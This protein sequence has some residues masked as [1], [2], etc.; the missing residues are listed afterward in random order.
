MKHH[1]IVVIGRG[2]SAY[3]ALLAF[4]KAGLKPAVLAP[5][6]TW[7][8]PVS[9][10]GSGGKSELARKKKFGS[11]D[12]YLYPKVA[13]IE[14]DVD[15]GIPISGTPGGLS[16]VWGSNIEVFSGP[17][18]SEWGESANQMRVA[19]AEVLCQ[20]PHGGSEDAL[21]RRCPW[22][23]DFPGA[24]PLSGRVRKALDT[25]AAAKSQ[26]SGVLVGLARNAIAPLGQGCI[27]CG[28]C[29]NGCPE[30]VIFDAGP[31]IA[32]LI[33]EFDLPVIDALA[34]KIEERETQTFITAVDREHNSK[35]VITASKV[36]LAAGSVATAAM[37]T[38]SEL[39]TGLATLDDTQVFYTPIIPNRAP[40]RGATTFTLAQ[41]F[42][43]SSVLG[44]TDFHLSVYESDTS[45]KE[46]AQGLIGPVAKL[47]PNRVYQHMMAGIGFIPPEFSGKIV[48]QKSATGSG[49]VN[50]RTRT[51][52][53]SQITVRA[54]VKKLS[55]AMRP[56]G[57]FP[58]AR[59][60]QISNVGA[61]YHAGN[62]MVDSK[63]VIDTHTGQLTSIQSVHVVD[64]AALP[65]L[66]TGPVTLTI[67]ANAYRIAEAVAR[68][69]AG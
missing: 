58:V 60:T 68:D 6:G 7:A 47:V 10:P 16:A 63:R 57:F 18:L 1:E 8:G 15:G 9:D 22:P 2:P 32:K 52:P 49:E 65:V 11:A 14:F 39:I 67:M 59:F 66:P 40:D 36:I 46:R 69:Y 5:A 38:G 51:N 50:V 23:V 17:D 30:G 61:S 41:L 33:V 64:G 31:A 24:Q 25:A 26:T 3:A 37:L 35:F 12:M 42:V 56:L 27:A 62:L 20:I 44:K 13:G 29:L 53:Q 43:I 55:S 54:A 19:Y 28:Q 21:S 48:I 45:F 4:T 34:T